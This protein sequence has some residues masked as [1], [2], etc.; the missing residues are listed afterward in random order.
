MLTTLDIADWFQEIPNDLA[1]TAVQALES[2]QVL[3]LPN[4][5]FMLSKEEQKFLSP[6]YADTRTKN[7]SYDINRH[8]LRGL[9]CDDD[10]RVYFENMMARFAKQS[11]TFL[12]QLLKHYTSSLLP[13]RT[14]FR[15]VE[16][17]GRVA[18]SY[19]KDDT[20]LHVDAFP[21][22]PTQGKRILRLF[23]NVNPAS[24]PRVWRLGAPFEEVVKQF[25]PSLKKPIFGSAYLLQALKITKARRTLYDHY[26]L[27]L[28]DNMKADL[29][30]QK[31]V[32]QQQVEF[33]A[34]SSWIVYTDQ[35]SHAAMAGQFTFEQTFY[36]PP[37]GLL[38]PSKSP[39]GVLEELLNRD[40][41]MS[42]I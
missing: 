28:H 10:E 31:Q 41:I 13:A 21:A 35:V 39:L 32:A 5:N 20:R 25:H 26:M 8:C 4:L 24:K 42:F 16:I 15:P 12:R 22:N 37:E 2:G 29:D 17:A 36:L 30:Y 6:Q 11:Q 38:E 3:F 7:I 27:Q 14:S 18:P 40:L 23:T 33:P 9:I 34:G 1:D 19:R